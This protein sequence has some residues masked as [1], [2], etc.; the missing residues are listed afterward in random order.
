M[1]V[2]EVYIKVNNSLVIF[3]SGLSGTGRTTLA[4]NI[5]RDFKLP[6]IN[7]NK[8]CIKDYNKTVKLPD[9]T[10]IVN[11]DSDDIYDW[12]AINQRIKDMQ[13]NGVIVVGTVFPTDKLSVKADFHIHIK[14]AKQNLISRRTRFMED[15]KEDCHDLYELN[16]SDK[17]LMIL[18]NVTLPYYYE[19]LKRTVITKYI[20]A[21][22][23]AELDK[24]EYNAKIYDESFDYLIGSITK[25]TDASGYIPEQKESEKTKETQKPDQP[26]ESVSEGQYKMTQPL[27]D[28]SSTT[29]TIS[30]SSNTTESEP[31]ILKLW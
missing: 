27:V 3:I 8:F 17:G 9:G 25:F 21:N 14:L 4:Q 24:D 2:V 22:D 6:I 29:P 18:N 16:K 12:S 20:S 13:H 1:N 19:S 10:D 5:S 30:S 15:H 23:Y 7:L 11:W 26:K 31:W 28:M